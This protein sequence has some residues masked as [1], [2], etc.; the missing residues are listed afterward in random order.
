MPAPFE[1][2]G[3]RG[4]RGLKPENTLP[5]FEAAL[6]LMVTSIETDIHLTSDCVPVLFHD[7]VLCPEHVRTEGSAGVPDPS[8]R[9]LIARL[10]W[11][12]IRSYVA[13]RNPDPARFRHQDATPTPAATS[14]ARDHGLA[15]YGIPRLE[16]FLG[17]VAAY[18]GELGQETG[19]TDAQRQRAAE[20]RF[21]L[22]LKRVPFRPEYSGD[23]FDGSNPGELERVVVELVR[24][25]NV[26]KRTT[27]QCFDHRAVKAVRRMEPRITGAVL[28]AP[29]A[30]VAVGPLVRAADATVYCP[31]FEALDA[32][33]VRQAQ[34]EGIRVVP[35]TVNA[36][37]DIERLLDWG[38]DG[39]ITDHP[40]QLIT[41]LGRR[42][43]KH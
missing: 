8:A 14:F 26:S 38:V 18:A 1:I 4:A 43:I 19:K 25:R 27:V 17:F 7:P 28:M 34:G 5:S 6:D 33:L 24:K 21:A 20:L 22:E 32:N 36:T 11:Q 23:S 29:T 37:E 30:P 9:P 3:H 40:N 31:W 12:Q 41:V 13:D 2:Q 42:G 15:L 16:D 39:M 10:S 35:Y